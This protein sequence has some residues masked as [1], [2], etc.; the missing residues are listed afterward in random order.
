MSTKVGRGESLL[1]PSASD[2]RLMFMFFP[3]AIPFEYTWGGG[4]WVERSPIKKSLGGG[5]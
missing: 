1:S 5:V 4:G 3:R 2:A